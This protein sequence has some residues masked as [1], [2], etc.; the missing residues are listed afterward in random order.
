MDPNFWGNASE[1]A[2]K[3][4]SRDEDSDSEDENKK[5]RFQG[6]DTDNILQKLRKMSV[7]ESDPPTVPQPHARPEVPASAGDKRPLEKGPDSDG[8]KKR[9]R[10]GF[11]YSVLAQ[12]RSS[13]GGPSQGNDD[14]SPDRI[15]Q[16]NAVGGCSTQSQEQEW[17]QQ[18]VRE[19]SSEHMS[20][21]DDM[22][23]LRFTHGKKADSTEMLNKMRQ[24]IELGEEMEIHM[25][26]LCLYDK[27]SR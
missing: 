1:K 8:P 12:L 23:G 18:R 7:Y 13:E 17:R 4:R 14:S 5:I 16:V 27:P 6:D 21:L 9:K 20:M 2:K 3:K 26:K 19:I 11:P 25:A 24:M 22:L 15:R 10:L